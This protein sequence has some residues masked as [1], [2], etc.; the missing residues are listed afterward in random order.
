[1]IRQLE[2]QD[3]N[4]NKIYR[5]TSSD[6]VWNLDTGHT[7]KEDIDT[8]MAA[9]GITEGAGGSMPEVNIDAN[10]LSGHTIEEL[11]LNDTYKNAITELNN[12]IA[13][14]AP[15]ASPAFTGTPTVPNVEQKDSTAKIANT[16]YVDTAAAGVKNDIVNI[17]KGYALKEHSHSASDITSGT[18]ANTAVHAKNGSDYIESRIRNISFLGSSEELPAALESGAMLA[19]YEG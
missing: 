13:G 1:M 16:T 17:L 10:T 4:G 18:F 6:I 5:H 9:L 11:V 12:A 14:K 8:L 3:Q 2:T 19:V 7:V 15:L